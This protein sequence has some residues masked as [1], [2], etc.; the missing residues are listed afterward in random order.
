MTC[1]LVWL[2]CEEPSAP[3]PGQDGCS[4]VVDVLPEAVVAEAARLQG[5]GWQVISEWPL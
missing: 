4:L 5:E 3:P 2:I 1:G